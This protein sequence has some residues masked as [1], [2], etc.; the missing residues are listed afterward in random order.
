MRWLISTLVLFGLGVAIV[1][2]PSLAFAQEAAGAAAG[3]AAE[4]AAPGNSKIGALVFWFFS[5]LCVQGAAP[6]YSS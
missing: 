4:E 5:L 1:A 3:A 6:E 2:S